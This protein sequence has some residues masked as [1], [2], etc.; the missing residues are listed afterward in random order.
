MLQDYF[1]VICFPFYFV[2]YFMTV[3][4]SYILIHHFSEDMQATVQYKLKSNL[5]SCFAQLLLPVRKF[6]LTNSKFDLSRCHKTSASVSWNAMMAASYR[7]RC[8]PLPLALKDECVLPCL[9]GL[10]FWLLKKFDSD[11]YS[12]G[13]LYHWLWKP[14]VIP[15]CVDSLRRRKI[16]LIESN[17]KRR[18]LK[19]LYL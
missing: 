10:R 13:C 14:N 16:R 6:S 12:C 2:I 4:Y 5:I 15:P 19:K 11:H 8:R 9:V 1:K 18:H 7:H 17:A 3:L